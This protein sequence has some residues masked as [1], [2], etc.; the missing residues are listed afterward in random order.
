MF[1]RALSRFYRLRHRAQ[2]LSEDFKLAIIVAVAERVMERRGDDVR[3][4]AQHSW[5]DW[6]HEDVKREL[7]DWPRIFDGNTPVD[8]GT[9]H[10]PNRMNAGPL[11]MPPEED[12]AFPSF[13]ERRR[14]QYVLEQVLPRRFAVLARTWKE[15]H[16][17]ARNL[18]QLPHDA[19]GIHE[20]FAG[21]IMYRELWMVRFV[22][23]YTLGVDPALSEA[24]GK[25]IINEWHG[26][27][28]DL[29]LSDDETRRLAAGGGEGEKSA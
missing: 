13:L 26:L 22:L 8:W 3:R 24:L 21:P 18:A 16:Q 28:V 12:P 7:A 1:Q 9:F 10:D 14:Q 15:A 11:R 6:D 27:E 2:Q 23:V 29:G 20:A 5:D 19:D 4:R 25:R 17:E